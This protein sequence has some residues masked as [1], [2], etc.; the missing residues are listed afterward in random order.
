VFERFT[1]QARQVVVLAQVEAR[2]LKHNHIGTEHILLGLASL[3]DGL[4]AQILAELDADRDAIGAE[5]LRAL[6]H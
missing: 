5:V 1:D 6:G 3:E 4:A 2:E